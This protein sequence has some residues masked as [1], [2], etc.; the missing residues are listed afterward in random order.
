M[1]NE[2]KELVIG[3]NTFTLVQLDPWRRLTFVADLQ[4]EFLRPLLKNKDE[5][6][7]AGLLN[8]G[9]KTGDL[10]M[11]SIISAFSGAIDAKSIEKW[12]RRILVDGLVIYTRED[13]QRAK[14]AF[15]ELNKFFTSPIDI[16]V[17]LREVIVLNMLNLNELMSTFKSGK[18]A[19]KIS[20][21]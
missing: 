10:D 8:S 18:H 9:E 4:H 19:G 21:A 14:L 17:L 11:M 5:N 12:M 1:K 3:E 6:D 16:L 13:G 7:L 2:T 20:E 15:S